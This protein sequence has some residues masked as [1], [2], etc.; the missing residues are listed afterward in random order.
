MS[1]DLVC[2]E[3][4]CLGS[5]PFKCGNL[6]LLQSFS[7]NIFDNCISHFLTSYVEWREPFKPSFMTQSCHWEHQLLYC[8]IRGLV[9]VGPIWAD[10]KRPHD[11]YCSFLPSAGIFFS[12]FFFFSLFSLFLP[13]EISLSSFNLLLPFFYRLRNQITKFAK[14]LCQTI[15]WAPMRTWE[16]LILLHWFS[17]FLGTMPFQCPHK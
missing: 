7:L 3:W 12:L 5:L 1:Q 11:W 17:L 14:T 16:K 4:A 9:V 8:S 15:K 6:F 10:A 13:V 2:F